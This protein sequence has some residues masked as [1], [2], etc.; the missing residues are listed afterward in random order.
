METEEI[1]VLEPQ[2]VLAEG[3]D[4]LQRLWMELV[5]ANTLISGFWTLEL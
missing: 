1:G 3:K 5:L 4:S 2:G